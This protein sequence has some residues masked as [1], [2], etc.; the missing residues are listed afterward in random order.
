MNGSPPHYKHVSGA[1]LCAG[2]HNHWTKHAQVELWMDTTVV[3]AH[4]RDCRSKGLDPAK[5]KAIV[6]IDAYSVHRSATMLALFGNHDPSAKY[7][8]FFIE[9]VPARCTSEFQIAD[10]VL[11]KPLKGAY[12]RRFVAHFAQQL[13]DGLEGGQAPED[14]HLVLSNKC[15]SEKCL[16]WLASAYAHCEQL[17]PGLKGGLQRLGYSACW[18]DGE[19]RLKL[20]VTGAQLLGLGEEDILRTV[21]EEPDVQSDAESGVDGEGDMGQDAFYEGGPSA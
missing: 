12:N 4:E 19:A 2:G 6:N 9:F 5:E 8:N 1:I 10:V 16:G 13:L 20:V 17:D 14:V 7:G 11:N 18:G 3:P 15:C 21:G